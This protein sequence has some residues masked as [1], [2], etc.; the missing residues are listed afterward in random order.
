AM[1]TGS[2][3]NAPTVSLEPGE[4]STPVEGGLLPFE[5]KGEYQSLGEIGRGGMGIVYRARQIRVGREVAVKMLPSRTC[6]SADAVA[7][8]KAEVQR[9]GELDHPNIVHVY[10]ADEQDGVPYFSM[11]LVKGQT[12]AE[13]NQRA[14]FGLQQAAKLVRVIA[15]AVHYAHE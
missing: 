5:R 13:V 11:E 1:E 2:L 8:L 14:P 10:D 4:T 6:H 15:G 7:R 9:L 3:A 12:L